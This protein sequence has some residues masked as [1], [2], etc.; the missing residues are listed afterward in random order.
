MGHISQSYPLR[1]PPKVP[2][3]HPVQL[4]LAELLPVL[5]EQQQSTHS[6]T[7]E[8]THSAIASI[9]A[10]FKSPNYPRLIKIPGACP[11]HWASEIAEL[12]RVQGVGATLTYLHLHLSSPNTFCNNANICKCCSP[13][14]FAEV[15]HCLWKR[16]SG[17]N[18]ERSRRGPRRRSGAE[19]L[20]V[21]DKDWMDSLSMSNYTSAK[22]NK[23]ERCYC[24]ESFL[25][26][27]NI[28]ALSLMDSR[29]TQLA[30][31]WNM[32]DWKSEPVCLML[33]GPV[34]Y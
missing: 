21:W 12:A 31:R 2:F 17:E 33:K 5:L 25:P 16:T 1:H 24:R 30:L 13:P 34:W 23:S 4:S 6:R 26:A 11:L 28:P 27:N 15:T 10:K 14:L 18:S 29:C 22:V 19:S 20:T 7:V 32:S 9:Q 8:F 3:F